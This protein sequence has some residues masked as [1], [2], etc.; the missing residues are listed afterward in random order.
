MLPF[1][2]KRFNDA[3]PSDFVRNLEGDPSLL[4]ESIIPED[5]S[6][7]VCFLVSMDNDDYG[8]RKRSHL[9]D[10]LVSANRELRLKMEI[11]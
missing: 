11:S 6:S 1:V 9:E 2:V 4:S 10:Q 3:I 7:R 8:K 5:R